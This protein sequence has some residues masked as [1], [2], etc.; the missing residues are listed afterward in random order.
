MSAPLALP[1]SNP[2][3]TR[4]VRPGA[5]SYR[6]PDGESAEA[7]IARLEGHGWR[8]A[9]IGPHGCGKSTL[10]HTLRP[11]LEA[12]GRQV[13]WITLRDGE[14]N[15]SEW[16]SELNTLKAATQLVIDGWEQLGWWSRSQ[17]LRLVRRGDCGLLVT[18]HVAAQV[19]TLIEI[20]PQLNTYQQLVHELLRISVDDSPMAIKPEDIARSYQYH[21][22]DV[23]EAFFELYDCYERY[24][25]QNRCHQ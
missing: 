15:L 3:S 9:I 5:I 6:F 19:P 25:R 23:R 20:V 14:R 12:R 4:F 11:V 18:S 8:G 22:G 13:V 7:L 10:L 24:Q 2:F 1:R 21:Q 16:T 17:A